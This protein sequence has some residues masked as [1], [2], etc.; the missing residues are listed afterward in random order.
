MPFAPL[1]VYARKAS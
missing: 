1:A